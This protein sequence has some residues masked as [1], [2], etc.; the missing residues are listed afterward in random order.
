MGRRRELVLCGLLLSSLPAKAFAQWGDPKLIAG[1]VG[2]NV[3]LSFLGKILLQHEPPR[4]AICEAL[5]EGSA[6]GLVAHAG[7]SIGGENPEWALVGK[8]LAQ[9]STLMTR[10]SMNGERV[11]DETLW[12]HW[13]LTHSFFYIK[14]SGRAAPSV[15]VDAVN[16]AFSSYYLLAGDPYRLD[17]KRSLLSGSLVFDNVDPPPRVRGYYVPGAIWI[18]IEHRNDRHVLGHEIIHSFQVERA[19]S[20]SEWHAG[21]FR[22]N[23]LSFGSGVPALLAG[24]P[25]HDNRIHEIEADLYSDTS[26]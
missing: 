20:I 15:Q 19:A 5:K 22:I 10:R 7:Y 21:I 18:D 9:K 16:A 13:E 17:A 26:R 8:A 24:W 6:S 12:T 3:A 25:D 2:F 23:W 1:Q 11:F 14:W 4:H